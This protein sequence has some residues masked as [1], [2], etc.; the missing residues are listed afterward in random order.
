MD[1]RQLNS[2]VYAIQY[3][4]NRKINR[5]ISI[6]NEHIQVFCAIKWPFSHADNFPM[7]KALTR[8]QDDVSVSK[9]M[10]AVGEKPNPRPKSLKF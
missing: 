9:S 6:I 3:T 4:T 10:P 1:L 2:I 7:P 5:Q 8:Y